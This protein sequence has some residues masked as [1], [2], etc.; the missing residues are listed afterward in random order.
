MQAKSYVFGLGYVA[1]AGFIWGCVQVL[2][3]NEIKHIPPL[4]IIAHRCIWAFV[5]LFIFV[6]FSTNLKSYVSIFLD[7]N[8]LVYLTS[9]A[10]LLS[11]NWFF[12]VKSVSINAVQDAA[13]GY[14][15]SPIFSV[16]FGYLFF[17]EKLNRIHLI[18]ILLIVF[19]IGNLIINLGS[20]PFIALSVAT[21]WSIYGLIKK[22]IKISSEIGLLFETSL[23]TP[24]FI[25]YIIF[26]N[27]NNESNFNVS[28]VKSFY[29]LIG[30]GIVTAVPLFFFN[31]GVKKI[32]LSF[33]GLMFYLVPTLQF[34]TSIVVL[35]EELSVLKL[36]SF[37]IIWLSIILFIRESM[38]VEKNI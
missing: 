7:S 35:K 10:L 24:F 30:S 8:K 38:K 14:F 2:Y 29:F 5:I 3:F 26:L 21:T 23:L 1:L 31:I 28:E 6:I 9:T 19:A 27:F 36:I 12:F 16:V 11:S 32:P 20:I 25:A 13:M 33:S 34:I 4:E 17:K 22:K 18:S 15:I 37:I